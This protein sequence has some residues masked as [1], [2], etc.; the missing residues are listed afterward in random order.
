M[1]PGQGAAL[2]GIGMMA[3]AGLFNTVTGIM[4][5]HLSDDFSVME[6]VFFRNVIA[7]EL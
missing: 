5:R 6:M 2:R 7:L 1:I 4:V 3:L